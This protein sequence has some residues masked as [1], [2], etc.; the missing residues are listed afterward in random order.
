MDRNLL[1]KARPHNVRFG[2]RRADVLGRNIVPIFPPERQAAGTL[3]ASSRQRSG[4]IKARPV[5][6]LE[7]EEKN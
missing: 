3:P 4:K 6:P 5:K 1:Y 7:Q 2:V